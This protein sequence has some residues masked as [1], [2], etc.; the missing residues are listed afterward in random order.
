MTN[1]GLEIGN[2]VQVKQTGPDGRFWL[3]A[4]VVF[5]GVVTFRVELPGSI[6]R[7]LQYSDADW[8]RKEA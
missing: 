3:D 5:V 8:R 4:T 2:K 1:P 7:T 6:L